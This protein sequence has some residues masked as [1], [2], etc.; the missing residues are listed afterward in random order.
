M[1]RR[2]VY[3]FAES[4]QGDENGKQPEPWKALA[5]LPAVQGDWV[6]VLRGLRGCYRGDRLHMGWLGNRRECNT[7]GSG[8]SRWGQSTDGSG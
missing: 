6:L 8:R 3:S 4:L 5:G 7:N 2:R 1:L